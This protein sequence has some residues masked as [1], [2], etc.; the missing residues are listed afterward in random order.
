MNKKN[1][2]YLI[3]LSLI[4]IYI[5]PNIIPTNIIDSSIQTYIL[6]P[7]IWTILAITILIISK[8]QQINITSFKKIRKWQIGKNPTQAAILIGCTQISL[9]F[10]SGIYMGFGQSPYSHTPRFLLTNLFFITSMIIS[11]ELTRAYIIKKTTKKKRN[12]TPIIALITIL[13]ALIYIPYNTIINLNIT[14][15]IEIITFIGETIIPMITISLFATYISYIGGS[16]PAISYMLIITGFEWFSP[17]LPDLNWPTMAFIKTIIPALGYIIIQSNIQT[18][19]IRRKISKRSKDQSMSWIIIASIGLVF[20]LVSTGFFGFQPT[21]IYS[22]SMNPEIEIGD[23]VIIKET[24]TDEI[25]KG[26]II[27][28]I[29]SDLKVPIIHRVIEKNTE[30]QNPVFITKGDANNAADENPVLEQQIVGKKIFKIPK[31]GWI[32]ITIKQTILNIKKN[33]L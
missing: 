31:I 7:I 20:V 8:K 14:N 5:L 11:Y 9:L 3:I 30:G 6:K 15:N 32:P 13:F 21:V 18:T 24:K 16:K 12:I 1:M 25:K 29:D 4:L 17:I 23:I 2:W 33:V 19:N 10:L 27:E 22:G 28:Y 26:D